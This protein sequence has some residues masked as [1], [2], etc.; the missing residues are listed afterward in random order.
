MPANTARWW[1][2]HGGVG[3]RLFGAI[4]QN[5]VKFIAA[6]STWYALLQLLL[7]VVAAIFTFL[8]LK[9]FLS[10]LLFG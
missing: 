9:I 3:A 2:H 6:T 10:V 7:F 1:L 5:F 4:N 8:L